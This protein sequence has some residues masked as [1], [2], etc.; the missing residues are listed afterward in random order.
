MDK[1]LFLG[2]L[3]TLLSLLSGAWL[4]TGTGT[5]LA[6]VPRDP[7]SQPWA[8]T[9]KTWALS[10]GPPDSQVPASALDSWKAFLGL[11]K[12]R[13]QSGQ[14]VVTA[15]TMSLPLDPQEVA[16]E[17]CKARPFTQVLSRPGCTA[18]RLRNYLCFGRCSSLYVPSSDPSP[19]VHCSSCVP[20]RK[21]WTSVVL[22]CWVG[23]PAAR[24]RR[25]MRMSTVLVEGC[26][27]SSSA[28]A[29]A[30]A[31]AAGER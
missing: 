29:A 28:A 8:A 30:A 5:G 15:T 7:Q 27:C 2:H 12:A 1:Q 26:Q 23:R 20:T 24:Q 3:T 14:E 4:P 21:R 31:A 6:P 16:R 9:N 18:A 25:Q 17:S 13:R 10:Q 11:Q 19:I 22:W